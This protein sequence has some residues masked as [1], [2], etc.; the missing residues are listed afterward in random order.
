MQRT[1]TVHV[2]YHQLKR[3]SV[4]IPDWMKDWI[5]CRFGARLREPPGGCLNRPQSACQC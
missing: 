3:N 5:N 4:K 1:I 2:A